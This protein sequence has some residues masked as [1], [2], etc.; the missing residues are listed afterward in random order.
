MKFLRKRYSN[1]D[2][3]NLYILRS[4]T[5]RYAVSLDF[6]SGSRVLEIGPARLTGAKNSPVFRSFHETFYDVRAMSQVQ[7]FEYFDMDL[8]PAVGAKFC[9]DIGQ[10]EHGLP[11]NMFDYVLCFSVLE[12][13][14]NLP[15]A[16]SNLFQSMKPGAELHIITPWDLRFHGPRPDC[17]RIS[18]DAYQYLLEPYAGEISIQ[19]IPGEHRPL[20]PVGLIVK[21]VKLSSE[22]AI[23]NANL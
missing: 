20:S 5:K 1:L 14:P 18:D 13:V 21:A 22:E 2:A 6:P 12:H 10:S 3:L 9:G 17:W 4:A 15:L 19:R 23:G 7:G 16:V 11:E 8:D